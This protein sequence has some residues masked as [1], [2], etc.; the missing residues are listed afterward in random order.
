MGWLLQAHILKKIKL[1]FPI[2]KVKLNE[3]SSYEEVE[4][5]M[6]LGARARCIIST[7]GF[8]ALLGQTS[9]GLCIGWKSVLYFYKW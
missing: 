2:R 6:N 1:H 9:L 3:G 7:H 8:S 4:C 5:L